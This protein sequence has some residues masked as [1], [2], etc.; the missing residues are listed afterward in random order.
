MQFGTCRGDWGIDV[1]TDGSGGIY[2][3]GISDYIDKDKPGHAWVAKFD[4]SGD[5]QWLKTLSSNG[6]DACKGVAVF[7]TQHVLFTGNT[8][9][10]LFQANAGGSDAFLGSLPPN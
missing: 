1:T 2:A 3:T 4:E 7:G 8:T 9:G 5:R 6:W 10:D